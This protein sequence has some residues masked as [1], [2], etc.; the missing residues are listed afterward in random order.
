[1]CLKEEEI[2]GCYNSIVV[3]APV[4]E[5]WAA[6]RNFHDMS[7][8]EQVVESVEAVG[9]KEGDQIGAKRIL[10]G[11]FHETLLALNEAER[12]IRYS[13]DDGPAALAPDKLTGYIGTVKLFSVTDDDRT[14]VEWTSTWESS[15][16]GVAEFCN[17]IYRALLADLKTY[18][19]E[20][21]PA[22][23]APEYLQP[24]ADP[25]LRSPAPSVH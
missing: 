3:D 18:F 25:M 12:T 21:Q 24:S 13:I 4:D 8:S 14:Y 10:N 22:R 7:W 9:E 15:S 11:A 17:P 16:G 23:E 19:A 20:E 1:V 6:M 2:M 5:V